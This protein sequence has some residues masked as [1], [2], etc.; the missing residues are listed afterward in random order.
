MEHYRI[1]FQEG[2]EEDILRILR[3]TRDVLIDHINANNI[4]ITIKRDHANELYRSLLDRI[5]QLVYAFRPHH[6]YF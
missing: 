4:V 2:E 6:G 5:D 3:S 1:D